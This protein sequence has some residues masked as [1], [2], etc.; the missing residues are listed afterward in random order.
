MIT[1]EELKNQVRGIEAEEH[2]KDFAGNVVALSKL[3]MRIGIRYQSKNGGKGVGIKITLRPFDHK[4]PTKKMTED[5]REDPEYQ[6]FVNEIA[7]CCSANDRP[8]DDCLA[9]GICEGERAMYDDDLDYDIPFTAKP[10][11]PAAGDGW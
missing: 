10:Q 5:F 11:L 1:D 6:K 2:L 4:I 8:C 9:G 3:G 7:E